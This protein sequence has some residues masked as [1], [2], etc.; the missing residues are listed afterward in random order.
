VFLVFTGHR[1]QSSCAGSRPT[2]A[3]GS[4][5]FQELRIVSLAMIEY[6]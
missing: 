5:I 6:L 1:E 2:A 3:C 4:G